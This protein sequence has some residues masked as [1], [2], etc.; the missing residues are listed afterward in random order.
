VDDFLWLE[1]SALS[2]VQCFDTVGCLTEGRLVRTFSD[3][4]GRFCCGGSDVAGMKNGV[5]VCE[6]V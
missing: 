2:F 6:V 3:C 1:S 4:P 5:S